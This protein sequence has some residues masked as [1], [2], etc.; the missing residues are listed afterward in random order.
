[1]RRF[2]QILILINQER[3]VAYNHRPGTLMKIRVHPGIASFIGALFIRMLAVTWR[4]DWRGTENL[5]KARMA[6]KQ[7]IFATWHGRLLVL[8]WTHRN[9]NIHV[10]ASEH[11]DGDLMGRIIERL[12]FGHVKGSTTRGGARAIR[13]LS[14]L[15]HSGIDVGL[16]VDGPRGPRSRV[17]QGVVEIGRLASCAIVPVTD[18]ARKR[19]LFK[20]WDRFQL[21]APFTRVIVEYG[22]PLIIMEK[23]STSLMECERLRLQER[24]TGMTAALDRELGHAGAE[25]WPHEDN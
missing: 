5:D 11:Y 15:L 17:K 19:Y 12:G 20:S 21:P 1:V 16:T 18:S 13:D 22:E 8:S 9:L 2:R 4:V 24:L 25:V 14:S 7:L 23:A 6:S 10:L 3:S